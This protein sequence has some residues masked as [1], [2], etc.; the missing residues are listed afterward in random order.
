[1]PIL[2]LTE[3]QVIELFRQM[4]SER[5]RELLRLLSDEVSLGLEESTADD[6]FADLPFFGMWADREDMKD[7]AAWVREERASWNQRVKSQDSSTQTS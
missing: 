1:M 3:E 4:P 5:K 7:S 6:G 2:S